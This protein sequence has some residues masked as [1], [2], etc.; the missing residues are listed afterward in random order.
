MNKGERGEKKGGKV[1]SSPFPFRNLNDNL[2]TRSDSLKV[3]SLSRVKRQG[4]VD[5]C[6]ESYSR[7][8]T[9]LYFHVRECQR[10]PYRIATF[11]DKGEARERYTGDGDRN[12]IERSTQAHRELSRTLIE[13]S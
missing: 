4:S 2:T 8:K 9:F 11:T 5:Y 13:H 1:S 6:I 12:R 10:I 3:K 7:G